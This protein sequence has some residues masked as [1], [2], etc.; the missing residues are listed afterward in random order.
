MFQA[1]LVV[2]FA[3][4]TSMARGEHT[5]VEPAEFVSNQNVRTGNRSA[6]EEAVQLIGNIR[7]G[8]RLVGRIAPTETGTIVRTNTGKSTDLRLNQL[9]SNGRV[10]WTSLHDDSGTPRTRAVNVKPQPT[11][12]HEFAAGRIAIAFPLR[13]R[14]LKYGAGSNNQGH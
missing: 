10:V 7:T 9:P 14:Q 2:G 4:S 5:D 12:V 6:G 1:I 3:L 13:H 8:A 11:D